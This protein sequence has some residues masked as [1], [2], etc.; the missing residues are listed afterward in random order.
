M[1]H[2]SLLIPH[3][4]HPWWNINV[5][6][7]IYKYEWDCFYRIP[8]RRRLLF[9]LLI[10]IRLKRS[11]DYGVDGEGRIGNAT[12]CLCNKCQ[13]IC[14]IYDTSNRCVSSEFRRNFDFALEIL[15]KAFWDW[16]LSIKKYKIVILISYVFPVRN[17]FYSLPQNY[18][19]IWNCYFTIWIVKRSFK[20]KF[21]IVLEKTY[22]RRHGQS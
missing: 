14:S 9:L 19:I 22:I 21:L 11:C 5:R 18:L 3:I 15:L 16:F 4:N 10:K 12:G 13:I 2:F 6:F 7:N 1:Y 20:I 17:F 8:A